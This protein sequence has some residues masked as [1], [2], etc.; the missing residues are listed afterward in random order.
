V[1]LDTLDWMREQLAGEPERSALDALARRVYGPR[2][3]ALTLDEQ[4]GETDEAKLERQALVDCLARA[5]DTELRTELAVRARAAVANGFDAAKLAAN[6][7]A[8]ALEVLAQDG[9]DA[10]FGALEQALRA[11]EDAQLR[12]DLVRA[13]G[14]ARA[15][16]RGRRARAL[17][18]DPAVRS[19]ELGT[20]LNSHFAWRE[21]RAIGRAWFR[22]NQTAILGK[23]PTL[24]AAYAP[25]TYAEGA[26]SESDARDVETRFAE[27]LA[28]LE[29]GP[30]ALAQLAESIRLCSALRAHQAQT[31]L[32]A[33]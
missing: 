29:G 30:R 13:L 12:R 28:T 21:N 4:P 7:R 8:S 16:E 1:P 5:G 18:L 23:L 15:P 2:L 10:E 26:C 33:F 3:A 11:A 27:P 32:G 22:G 17:A 24:A 25:F 14:A 31:G 20:L 9:S 6:Q 19:G